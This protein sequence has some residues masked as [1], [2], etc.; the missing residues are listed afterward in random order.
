MFSERSAT[1]APQSNLNTSTPGQRTTVFG[2]RVVGST[3]VVQRPYVFGERIVGSTPVVQRPYVFGER[4][5]P[6]QP[7]LLHSGYGT[8]YQVPPYNQTP[9][10]YT[11]QIHEELNQGMQNMAIR[12]PPIINY[13]LPQHNLQSPG[14]IPRI[15]P[16]LYNS[17][18]QP[19]HPTTANQNMGYD[20]FQNAQQPLTNQNES[21]RYPQNAPA[22]Q[23][24]PQNPYSNPPMQQ[25]NQQGYGGSQGDN[26]PRPNSAPISREVYI[27]RC[28]YL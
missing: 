18:Y 28:Y 4:A 15:D 25:Q 13:Q 6:L 26:I 16:R 21:H 9:A 24:W 27:A 14:G 2:Q 19:P 1:S 3:P 20:S 23:Q 10:T 17:N 8:S 12:N 7:S 22:N 5:S 11:P